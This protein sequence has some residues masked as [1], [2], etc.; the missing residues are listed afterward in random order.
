LHA[1]PEM[2]RLDFVY[3]GGETSRQ[4]FGSARKMLVMKGI[5][6]AV[7]RAEHLVA[8]KIQAMKNDP[9]RTLQEMADI[10]FLLHLPEID[11]EEVKRYFEMQ[12]LIEKYNEI[13]KILSTP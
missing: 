3:V 10:L 2:G 9:A 13:K 12:G 4:L 7:P 11:E 6:V 1:D 5:S 8:M